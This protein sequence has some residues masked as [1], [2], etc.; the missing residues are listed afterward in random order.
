MILSSFEHDFVQEESAIEPRDTSTKLLNGQPPNS[1]QGNTVWN[2]KV[3]SILTFVFSLFCLM[4]CIEL[5]E[6]YLLLL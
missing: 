2:A 1:E 6:G 5:R 4:N 3:G